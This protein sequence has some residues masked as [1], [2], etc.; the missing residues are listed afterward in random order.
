MGV[1]VG[2]VSGGEVTCL[3]SIQ[4]VVG[5]V[6]AQE[7]PAAGTSAQVLDHHILVH[8]GAPS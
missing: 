1:V 3:D 4:A 7:H 5:H 8:K 6:H 2:A